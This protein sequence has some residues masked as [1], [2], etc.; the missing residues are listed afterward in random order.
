MSS[1]GGKVHASLAAGDIALTRQ[2]LDEAEEALSVAERQH[3]KVRARI[4]EMKDIIEEKLRQ[5]AA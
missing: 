3:A 5:S 1:R 2:V 4:A